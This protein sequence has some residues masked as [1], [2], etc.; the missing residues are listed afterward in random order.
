MIS[1]ID[2][3]VERDKMPTPHRPWLARSMALNGNMRTSVRDG[4]SFWCLREGYRYWVLSQPERWSTC[5]VAKE[6]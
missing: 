5:H 2:E 3:F 4:S 6:P 1:S